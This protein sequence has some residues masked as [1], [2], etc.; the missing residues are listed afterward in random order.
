MGFIVRR[1]RKGKKKWGRN[2]KKQY[3]KPELRMFKVPKQK[4]FNFKR[5]RWLDINLTAPGGSAWSATSTNWLNTNADVLAEN[6]IMNFAC[7]NVENAGDPQYSR[8][9]WQPVFQ[10]SAL[11]GLGD[12]QSLYTLYK[13]NKVSITLYPMRATNPVQ[14]A[15]NTPINKIASNVIVTTMYAKSGLESRIEYG[16]DELS[17]VIRKNTK[18]YNLGIGDKK[19]GWYFTPSVNKLTLRNPESGIVPVIDPGTAGAK[20]NINSAFASHLGKAGWQ[21]IATGLN[22]DHHGPIVSIRTV[23]GSSLIGGTEAGNN[24]QF[25]ACIKYYFSCKG[26]R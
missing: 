7:N 16:T 13:I 24:F 5:E 15:S 18:M 4:V 9:T 3:A 22:T 17:Q 11:P 8:V 6:P 21:D 2:K 12:I 10:F 14:T 1:N 26:V 25:R 23:D 20:V 19:L